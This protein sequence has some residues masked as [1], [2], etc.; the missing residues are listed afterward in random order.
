[1]EYKELSK[2]QIIKMLIAEKKRRFAFQL[3]LEEKSK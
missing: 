2:E 3:I 1:M